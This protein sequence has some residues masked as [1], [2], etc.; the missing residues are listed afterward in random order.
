MWR[1]EH[2]VL[3]A[4]LVLRLCRGVAAAQYTRCMGSHRRG[5]GSPVAVPS[6]DRNRSG[7]SS[8]QQPSVVRAGHI[9]PSLHCVAHAWR[10]MRD[11]RKIAGGDAPVDVGGR[12]LSVWTRLDV[13]GN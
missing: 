11:G 12:G 1:R 9:R 7:P 4:W 8:A 5:I 13:L 3:C 10:S 2:C 6:I